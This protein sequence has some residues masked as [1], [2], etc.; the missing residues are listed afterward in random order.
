[1]AYAADRFSYHLTKLWVTSFDW[2]E[3]F[4]ITSRSSQPSHCSIKLAHRWYGQDDVDLRNLEEV[5]K[6]TL[7]NVHRQPEQAYSEAAISTVEIQSLSWFIVNSIFIIRK[8]RSTY[9]S[10]V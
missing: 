7:S 2:I 5:F 9:Y 6:I 3:G 4:H 8:T 10:W 1:V